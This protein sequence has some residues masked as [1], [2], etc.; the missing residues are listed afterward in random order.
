MEQSSSGADSRTGGQVV[1][2]LIEPEGLLP[3]SPEFTTGSY[4]EQL[5]SVHTFTLFLYYPLDYNIL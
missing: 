1:S 5:E 3:C 4:P 2:C